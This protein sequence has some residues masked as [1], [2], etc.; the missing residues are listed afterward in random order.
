M[1]L[2]LKKSSVAAACASAE[3]ALVLT[4]CDSKPE[5]GKVGTVEDSVTIR[6]ARWGNDYRA[7]TSPEVIR[8][9]EAANPT[10]KIQGENTKFSSYRDK[11]E[12]WTWEEA[13]Q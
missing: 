2:C 12:T 4:G 3:L 5:A 1:Q 7:K 13:G 10:V 11:V 8:D 9:F 6:F